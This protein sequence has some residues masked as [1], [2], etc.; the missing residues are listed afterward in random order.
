MSF[1]A[2]QALS[3]ITVLPPERGSFP[4]DHD[5]ECKSIMK[6]YLAC[7]RKSGGS[8]TKCRDLSKKYLECRMERGLMAPDKMENLGFHDKTR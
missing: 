2:P 5:G 4:L 6:D 8:S 3:N 7:M 1:G